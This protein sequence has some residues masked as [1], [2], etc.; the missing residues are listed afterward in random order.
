MK[1][2][3]TLFSLI[4]FL[5]ITIVVLFM[6]FLRWN[7][8]PSLPSQ[9]NPPILRL[10]EKHFKKTISK[11]LKV[12]SYNIHFGIGSNVKTQAVDKQSYIRRL[13]NIA[14]V[15][16]AID[17]DIVLL[18]EVDFASQRSHLINQAVYIAKKTKYDYIAVSPTLKKKFHLSYHHMNGQI[19]HGMAILSR[20]PI[21]NNEAFIFEYSKEIPFFAKWL[22]DPHGAQ[23]CIVDYKGKKINI[24]NVHLEPWDK[25]ERERQLKMVKNFWLSSS[26][27]PIILAGD[28]NTLPL[29]GFK[30]NGYYLSDA[31]WFVDRENLDIKDEK[32]LTILA[33]LG[34]S[35]AARAK[36]YLKNKKKYFTYPSIDPKEKIDYIFAGNGA[37]TIT[38]YVYVEAKTTSDH[39]PIYADIKINGN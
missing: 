1:I 38:G 26:N 39:L 31:P 4:I 24:I 36:L 14:D 32:T 8:H 2:L 37:R 13:N 5:A 20:Y 28:F 29:N 25:R 12:V 16:N 11:N 35:E 21:E 19:E 18:Q 33:N 3:K 6:V 34:Y 30:K 17:A 22:Y 27:Y 10:K 7:N 15:L 23:K 9:S